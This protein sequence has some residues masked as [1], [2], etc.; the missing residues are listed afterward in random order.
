MYLVKC[1]VVSQGMGQTELP[2]IFLGPFTHRKATAILYS[3]VTQSSIIIF[4]LE[5]G[6]VVTSLCTI[7]KVLEEIPC[8]GTI[9]VVTA[10]H[11][12]HRLEELKDRCR[13]DRR[14]H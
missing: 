14:D 8:N 7:C 4:L 2:S 13:A 5:E 10:S 3:L 1:L 9:I 12:T 11:H 6:V